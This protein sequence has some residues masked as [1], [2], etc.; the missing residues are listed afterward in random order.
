MTQLGSVLRGSPGSSLPRPR[1]ATASA[2]RSA[3]RPP[4]GGSVRP[5]S[6][7]VG[8]SQKNRATPALS[9]TGSQRRRDV[10]PKFLC[11]ADEPEAVLPR[12][13]P[14]G[15]AYVATYTPFEELVSKQILTQSAQDKVHLSVTEVAEL[16]RAKCKDQGLQPSKKRECR[17]I[18]LLSQNC[19]G[20]HFS[21]RENG[22]GFHSAE[23]I[24]TILAENEHFAV[25]DLSGNRLKDLGAI[26]IAELLMVNDALVHVA[27]KSNDIGAVGAEKIAEALEANTTVTS[28]DVSG[29]SGIN[30]NHLGAIGARAMGQAL[31]VN[32]TLAIL[33]LGANGLG[34]EGLH[35][36]ALGLDGNTTLTEL[37]LGSNNLGW[38]SCSEL[39]HLLSHRSAIQV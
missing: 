15:M 29:L 23:C 11:D 8:G 21:L 27:L 24:A 38:E 13:L 25:L 10:V 30:R 9:A 36:I 28:L 2:H 37:D 14:P 4:T 22:L 16:Y 32:Q 18:Q 31:S 34:N 7:L 33:N 20:M 5:A 12:P 19:K 26:K 39:G 6:A 1:P 35:L 3:P 17:Y